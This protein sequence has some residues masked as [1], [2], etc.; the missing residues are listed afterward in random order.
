MG[1]MLGLCHLRICCNSRL[2]RIRYS[3]V[4]DYVV[5]YY[6]VWYTVGVLYDVQFCGR[7]LGKLKHLE[8]G[9]QSFVTVLLNYLCV[10]TIKNSKIAN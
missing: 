4:S 2:C 7:C 1:R 5:R 3:V 9:I 6:V 8:L 10:N